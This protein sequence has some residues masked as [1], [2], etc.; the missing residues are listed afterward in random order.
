MNKEEILEALD[1]LEIED[2]EE[3]FYEEDVENDSF[4]CKLVQDSTENVF[5]LTNK[6]TNESVFFSVEHEYDSWCGDNFQSLKEL[7]KVEPKQKT[8]TVYEEVVNE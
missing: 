6:M 8:I 7:K 3:L 2:H 1:N 5:K 4:H